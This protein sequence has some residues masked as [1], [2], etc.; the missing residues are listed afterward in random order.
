MRGIMMEDEEM[1]DEKDWFER[2]AEWLEKFGGWTVV[3]VIATVLAGY[4]VNGC[5]TH[6]NAERA[7][8]DR[9][10]AVVRDHLAWLQ[11]LPETEKRA[12]PV[13]DYCHPAT[14]SNGV[15]ECEPQF[16][17]LAVVTWPERLENGDIACHATK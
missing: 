7:E 12:W 4:G 2:F 17:D 14:A 11:K 15:C 10:A 1:E 5:V 6:K 8:Y 13:R 9:H 3:V 16:F